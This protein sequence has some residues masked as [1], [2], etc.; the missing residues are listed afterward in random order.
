LPPCTI[1]HHIHQSFATLCKSCRPRS[2]LVMPSLL[3]AQRCESIN[4]AI[5]HGAGCPSIN[6]VI[7]ARATSTS[8]LNLAY[9]ALGIIVG[10]MLLVVM[11]A[12][13]IYRTRDSRKWSLPRCCQRSRRDG[14]EG[15]AADRERRGRVLLRR[16]N[17]V[18]S[19]A[20]VGS[21]FTL[22][23]SKGYKLTPV[24]RVSPRSQ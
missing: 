1:W 15:R 18:T 2:R 11:G 8:H 12:L 6:S 16:V 5:C 24:E 20:K 9:I 17:D 3:P 23:G 13:L 22:E 19:E 4:S 14:T 7:S 10:C 21:T